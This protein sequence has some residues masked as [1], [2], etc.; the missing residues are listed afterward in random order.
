MQET[1]VCGAQL[2]RSLPA[3]AH[4][5]YIYCAVWHSALCSL[6]KLRYADVSGL[7]RRATR[8]C[9]MVL[10]S[11]ASNCKQRTGNIEMEPKG[12]RLTHCSWL[13]AR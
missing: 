5:L 6:F 3:T 7:F 1:D 2:Y 13:H 11:Q 8:C 10:H 4:L 12:T 9:T